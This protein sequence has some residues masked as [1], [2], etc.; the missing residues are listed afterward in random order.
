MEDVLFP[1]ARRWPAGDRRSAGRCQRTC[2]GP[3]EAA[4]RFDGKDVLLVGS[5]ST[6]V[7]CAPELARVCGSLTMLQRSPS[8]IYEIDNRATPF[9][10]LCQSLYKLGL[11][12]PIKLLRAYLQARDEILEFFKMRLM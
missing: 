3:G 1:H 4:R 11:D 9:M 8:Y 7:C 10:R 12:F 5:G 2:G 6:A